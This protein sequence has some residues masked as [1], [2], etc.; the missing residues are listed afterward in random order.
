MTRKGKYLVLDELSQD[1]ARRC[2]VVGGQFSAFFEMAI[3]CDA[4]EIYGCAIRTDAG[5]TIG[6]FLCGKNFE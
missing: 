4:E 5:Q 3:A 1:V 6:W 2:L